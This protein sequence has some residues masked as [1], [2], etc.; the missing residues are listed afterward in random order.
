MGKGSGKIPMASQTE[1]CM[2]SRYKKQRRVCVKVMKKKLTRIQ[3][4][5]EELVQLC[6]L[7]F[8][9]IALE[10]DYFISSYRINEEVL[11]HTQFCPFTAT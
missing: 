5:M 3:K 4:E 9:P 7:Y 11:V 1:R 8:K 6:W 10:S 2:A